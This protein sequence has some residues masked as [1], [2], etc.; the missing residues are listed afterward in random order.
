MYP[1]CAIIGKTPAMK[2]LKETTWDQHLQLE[3]RLAIKDRFSE[4]SAYRDH[5][6]QLWGFHAAAEAQ[7]SG[8]LLDS[9]D[10]YPARL[11]AP[12][13]ARDIE[14]LGGAPPSVLASVPPVADQIAALGG[15]YVLEGATLGGQHLLPIVQRK[16]GLSASHGASYLASYGP[17]VKAM[18]GR[19][20]AVVDAR[21]VTPEAREHA[22]ATARATFLALETW[23]CGGSPGGEAHG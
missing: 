20:C 15:F 5:L 8:F 6:T 22:S 21:C 1:V 16:L 7:W 18:W 12:L 23:L 10:D 19:F 9:L 17:D 3:K 11:K 13:L 14:T 4:I 2:F